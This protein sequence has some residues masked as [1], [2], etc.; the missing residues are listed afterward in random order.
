MLPQDMNGRW[1]IT[2]GDM[3]CRYWNGTIWVESIYS[4]MEFSRETEAAQYIEAHL[5]AMARDASA[6]GFKA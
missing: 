5:E 4:A 2:T 1:V 6:Q 3:N